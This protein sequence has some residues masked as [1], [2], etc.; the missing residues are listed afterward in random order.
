MHVLYQ[1]ALCILLD[2]TETGYGKE[3][4]KEEY[5]LVL[6]L[7]LQYLCPVPVAFIGLGAVSAAVMSSA[8]SSVF[9]ASTMFAKNVYKPLREAICGGVIKLP[10]FPLP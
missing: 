5:A 2:W 4:P 7:V 8:D 9:S 3:I 6:P 1:N 10:K